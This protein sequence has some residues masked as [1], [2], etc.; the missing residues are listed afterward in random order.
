MEFNLSKKPVASLRE[1]L[2]TVSEQPV[3]I[4]FTLPDYCPDIEKILH[5]KI[6]PKIYNRNING[7]QLRIEGTSVVSVLY[8]DSEKGIVRV[9]EQSLPFSASFRLKENPDNYVIQAETKPEYINCRALSRR[10]LT[11][12]GAFSLFAKVL[13]KSELDIFLPEN[14]DNIELKKHNLNLSALS[15]I[16]GEQFSVTDEIQITGKPPVE[17]IIDSEVKANITEYRVIPDKLMLSG[18]LCVRVLYISDVEVGKTE[19][20]DYI[21]PF[22][23]VLDCAGIDDNCSVCVKLSVMSYDLSLKSDIL[24]ENPLI[25]IDARICSTVIGYSTVEVSVA[26]DAYSTEFCSEPEFI[27]LNAPVDTKKLSDTFMFKD[28]FSLDDYSISEIIDFNVSDCPL[29][30]NIIEGKIDLASKLN[31]GILVLDKDNMPVY[32]ERSLDVN[33]GIEL[34]DNYN[35]V[36][37]SDLS[38]LSVSYRLIDDNNIEVRCELKYNIVVQSVSC[39]NMVSAVVIDDNK[40]ISKKTCAL[41]LY[42]A[43]KGENIWD[44]AKMYNTRQ[45]IIKAENKLDMEALEQAIM[46]LIPIV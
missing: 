17:M 23:Q 6:S 14:I 28:S 45:D 42:Y 21:V 35:S 13:S 2:N 11:I 25:I 29:K 12:H 38:L 31:I 10:R 27:R 16:S 20:L 43:E 18:D 30:A 37:C 8:Q 44:I 24:S 26:E 22:S 46:L 33:R 39:I 41:T 40:P 32:I 3:D 34:S 19:Q 36:V 7:G 15:S 9:C 5:C 4:D 1:V